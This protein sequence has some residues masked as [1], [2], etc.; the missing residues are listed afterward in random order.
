LYFLL[1]KSPRPGDLDPPVPPLAGTQ[2]VT[3]AKLS[4]NGFSRFGSDGRGQGNTT[5]RCG[6]GHVLLRN[7]VCVQDHHCCHSERYGVRALDLN[8]SAAARLR[9]ALYAGIF[10]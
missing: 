3:Q 5:G 2:A 9:K 4:G 6:G 10:Q 1:N 7:D 8:F